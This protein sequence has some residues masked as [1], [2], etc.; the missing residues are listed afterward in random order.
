MSRHRDIPAHVEPPAAPEPAGPPVPAPSVSQTGSPSNPPAGPLSPA[1]LDLVAEGTLT[2]AQ[3]ARVAERLAESGTAPLPVQAPGPT[4]PGTERR[5]R[6]AEVAGYLG[7]AL[8]LGAAA[9]FLASGWA[10][11]SRSGRV[12]LMTVVAAAL[13]AGGAL[14]VQTSDVSLRDVVRRV[15][16]AESRLG[17][18]RQRL[19]SVLWAF[20]SAAAAFAAGLAAQRWEVAVG[21]AVGLAL[22]IGG[23][24]LVRG[25]VG[26]LGMWIGS[27]VLLTSLVAE[28]GDEPGSSSYAIAL[29][30]LGAAWAALGL[31]GLVRD[32]EVALASGAGLALVAAQL[33]V[34]NDSYEILG[35]LLTTGV[36]VAGFLGHLATRSWSVLATGVIA[37]T[38]VVPEALWNWTDG[39]VSVAG[40]LLAAGLSLL[41][42]SA[43]GLR[44]RRA[45]A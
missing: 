23:Y 1:L 24:L 29:V 17:P 21:S 30:P 22:A 18:T 16:G 27:I 25:A 36:A 40:V 31:T 3:A 41:G 12:A 8:L 28:I 10:D 9:L 5:G 43:A 26:Q 20:A 32:R 44:L 4:T 11:L 6:L 14:V 34:L 13:A 38:L 37:T 39:S 15:R 19:V 2:G 33:P 42:A 45:A 7:A 35:Y